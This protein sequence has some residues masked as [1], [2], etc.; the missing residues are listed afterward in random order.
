M[1]YVTDNNYIMFTCILNT[2]KDLIELFVNEHSFEGQIFFL[3]QII[4][5]ET[6]GK[7]MKIDNM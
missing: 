3:F 5:Y 1:F 4:K 6:D 7:Y 2:F